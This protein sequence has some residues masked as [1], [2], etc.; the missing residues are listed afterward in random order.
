M[1]IR[2]RRSLRVAPGLKLNI[3]T[4]SVSA[5]VGKRS[6]WYTVGSKGR[7]LTIGLPGTGLY[8]TM[9]KSPPPTY[10][11]R[12]L[13]TVLAIAVVIFEILSVLAR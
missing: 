5:S 9:G 6:L 10:L 3:G 4:K 8:W 11:L 2:F 12:V 7:R 13:G 1:G